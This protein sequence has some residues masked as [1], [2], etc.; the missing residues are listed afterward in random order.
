MMSARKQ[1]CHAYIRFDK[2]FV[3]DRVRRREELEEIDRKSRIWEGNQRQPGSSSSRS[4]CSEGGREAG[5]TAR[6]D[7]CRK[8][9]TVPADCKESDVR[10]GG[11]RE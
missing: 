9:K 10:S 4:D 8:K 6:P 7:D 3:N 5:G 2:L 1:G 11:M